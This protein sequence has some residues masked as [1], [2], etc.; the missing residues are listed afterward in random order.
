ML[1]LPLLVLESNLLIEIPGLL[2]K[3]NSDLLWLVEQEALE[4][5]KGLL[6][7]RCSL[8]GIVLEDSA[9]EDSSNPED[10]SSFDNMLRLLLHSKVVMLHSHTTADTT[11]DSNKDCIIQLEDKVLHSVA[12]SQLV[13]N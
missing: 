2:M 9:L 12:S 11:T 8:V 7:G 1:H 6:V 10:T 3:M 4:L 5:D 13:C